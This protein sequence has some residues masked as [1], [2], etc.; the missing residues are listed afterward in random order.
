MAKI[1]L[2]ISFVFVCQIGQSQSSGS[3]KSNANFEIPSLNDSIQFAII[4]EMLESFN[5]EKISTVQVNHLLR[6]ITIQHSSIF[7]PIEVLAIIRD[8][9]FEAI[10]FKDGKYWQ[11][12]NSGTILI[13]TSEGF[14]EE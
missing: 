14:I 1:L 2:S 4:D 7:N 3:F 9:G 5:P 6:T 12:N 13:E 10:Y 11:L 8:Y